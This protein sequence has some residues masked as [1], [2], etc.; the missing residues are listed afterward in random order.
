MLGKPSILDAVHALIATDL[1]LLE[2]LNTMMGVAGQVRVAASPESQI[3]AMW[4]VD[5]L[6][7]T[8]EE[9]WGFIHLGLEGPGLMQHP[10]ISREVLERCICVVNQRLQGLLI[11]G[12]YIH[13][14]YSNGTHTCLAGRG[15]ARSLN[16]GYVEQS[17]DAVNSTQRAV[18]CVGPAFDFKELA[19]KAE[20]K[21]PLLSQFAREANELTSSGSSRQPLTGDLFAPLLSVLTPYFQQTPTSEYENVELKTTET[22]FDR[23]K[24]H[25]AAALT[26]RQWLEE[27]SPLTDVQR[28]ILF[29][30]A[31]E[32]HPLRI[33]GPGGSGKT[34]LMQLLALRRLD[35]RS[36]ERMPVRIL[37]IVH[38]AAMRETVKQ[39]FDI[40]DPEGVLR[41][42]RE[43]TLDIYT[44]AEYG[45]EKLELE[46][47]AVIDPDAHEAKLFQFHQVIEAL[48]ESMANYPQLVKQSSLFSA[49]DENPEL[50]DVLG[51]LIMNEISVAI[52]GHGLEQDQRRYVQS[53]QSLSRF[54]RLLTSTERELVYKT[55][56]RYHQVVFEEFEVLD[57]DDIALSL[58]GRLR[59]PIWQLKRRKEGYDF[60]FVDETQ[61]FNENERRVFSLLPTGGLGHVPVVL[62]LDEAQ[63]IYGQSTAGLA[64]LGIPDITNESL[65]AIHR[66]TVDIVRLAFFVIQRSTDLFGVDFPDFTGIAR[67]MEPSSH[68][69]ASRPRVEVAGDG[70]RA[71]GRFVIKRVRALRKSNLRRIAVICHADQYWDGLLSEMKDARLPL[72]VLL[73][74]GESL[75]P[76][77]P[78]V[79]L[80]RPPYSG[81]QEFDAVV[82]VGLEQGVVPPRVVDNEALSAAVEQQNLREIYLA[83]TRAKY[84]LVVVLSAGSA[85]TPIL[86]EAVTAGYLDL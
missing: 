35:A 67:E 25:Q 29:S 77:E 10:S 54:H 71:L 47:D 62:A 28:R 24:I 41:K 44:L 14:S 69:L 42:G 53:Q 63:D 9:P 66:S 52:K 61:L 39:R 84:R 33:V 50:L 34:L 56:E 49:V 2:C 31:V 19:D 5:Y 86:A 37:Y 72:Q 43:R 6:G 58:L 76:D 40:L 60:V 30:D 82:L 74:R 80:T 70:S 15:Q 18:L 27:D 51:F 8:G 59:T 4:N 36:I 81:G 78:I 68:P 16:I 23:T 12:A 73:Q 7:G 83:V 26:Y 21:A 32:R 20:A 11:D 85:L 46:H 48:V 17:V 13:R 79:V 64:T 22:E 1:D 38:N 55:Y 57:S 65:D 45:R 3:L 75:P